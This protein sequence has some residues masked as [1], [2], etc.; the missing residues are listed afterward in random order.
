MQ[1]RV[2]TLR[3]NEALQGFPEDVLK[4]ATFGREVLNVSEHFFVHGNVPHLTL[5]LSLGDSPRYENAGSYRPRDPNALNP[6][7]G[8]TDE[9]KTCYRAL[10]TWRNETAK[11]EGRPAYAI[12]RNT[13]LAE[14]VK[15]MPKSRSAI[16]EID[17]LGE[18]FC[19]KYGKRVLELMGDGV[20]TQRRRE[21]ERLGLRIWPNC[22]RLKRVRFLRTRLTFAWRVRQFEGGTLDEER[23]AQ[24]AASSDGASRWFGF[25]GILNDLASK[26]GSSSGSNRLKRGGSWNNNADNCT[27]SNRN[28]NN[29]F[30]LVSTV[31]EQ[32]GFNFGS[33]A[34]RRIGDKHARLTS[35]SSSIA[36]AGE[37][38]ISTKHKENEE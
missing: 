22:W 16:K 26:E 10:K 37:A 29:G 32:T 28:N 36:A 34:L 25:K 4:V 23:F 27:S 2:V 12:A 11:L 5:V 19:E 1:I 21:A 17:G 35:V 24:C 14:L 8:L 20:L 15:A 31:S 6:E 9:Q 30:R 38:L 18:G 7:D 13:Q 3:Y 33:P